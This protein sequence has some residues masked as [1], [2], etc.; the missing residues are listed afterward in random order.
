M[1]AV[2]Q[3]VAHASVSTGG[4]IVGAIERGF[5]ALVGVSVDDDER[6]AD[7]LAAKIAGLR[8]FDDAG[9]GD[10]GDAGMGGAQGSCLK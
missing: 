6:D 2:V 3:R 5:V 8:V 1:R 10:A 7:A 4:E 9:A